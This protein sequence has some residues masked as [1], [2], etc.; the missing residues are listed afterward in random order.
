M[1]GVRGSHCDSATSTYRRKTFAV[2]GFERPASLMTKIQ[3]HELRQ[4]P[5][6]HWC[7]CG[8]SRARAVGSSTGCG[9]CSAV[10][11]HSTLLYH[12]HRL[13]AFGCLDKIKVHVNPHGASPH[14]LHTWDVRTNIGHL[15]FAPTTQKFPPGSYL[16]LSP[17]SL[18]FSEQ[19]VMMMSF[20][21]EQ[22]KPRRHCK[23]KAA[24]D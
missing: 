15:G 21:S 3:G 14:S 17:I 4:K 11:G 8:L 13:F 9:H 23:I 6:F 24:G 10:L 19:G 2:S 1:R 7:V 16:R 12:G 5:C 22:A 20:R 18:S